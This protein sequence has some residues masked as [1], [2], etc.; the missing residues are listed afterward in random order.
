MVGVNL[1]RGIYQNWTINI[2][3]LCNI[4][5][6]NSYGFTGAYIKL[7]SF[8]KQIH[9]SSQ[10][11]RENGTKWCLEVIIMVLNGT[12]AAPSSLSVTISNELATKQ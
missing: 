6:L 8:V 4:G 12:Y 11:I 10:A 5:K 2:E 7:T 1:L 3:I 9:A